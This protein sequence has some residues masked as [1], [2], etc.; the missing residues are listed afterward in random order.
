MNIEVKAEDMEKELVDI[1]KKNEIEKEVIVSS[2]IHDSLIKIKNLCPELKVAPLFGHSGM[3]KFGD[4]PL[5]Y[6]DLKIDLYSIHI[7]KKQAN[8]RDIEKAHK[9]GLK[10][11]VYTSN[12]EKEMLNLMEMGV[13]G[14]FTDKPDLLLNLKKRL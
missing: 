4:I 12:E 13:D 1:I 7:D 3:T 5:R 6:D 9:K 11:F 10:V 14:I 2:F 8:K